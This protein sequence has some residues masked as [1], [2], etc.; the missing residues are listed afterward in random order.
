MSRR[1]VVISGVDFEPRG[2][3]PEVHQ[4]ILVALQGLGEFDFEYRP[5]RRLYADPVPFAAVVSEEIPPS[6]QVPAFKPP[7]D[8]PRPTLYLH[9]GYAGSSW[10][11]QA[12]RGDEYLSGAWTR[13]LERTLGSGSPLERLDLVAAFL[14]RATVDEGP[15]VVGAIEP[16]T[17]RVRSEVGLRP[18]LNGHVFISY[19]RSDA[20]RV[21]RM[22]KVLRGRGYRVW[23]DREDLAVGS[24]WR[25]EIAAA[26]RSGT[27]MV[28]CFS[29]AF[30]ARERSYMNE[31]LT[32]AIEEIRARPSDR[33]W[34]FPVRLDDCKIPDRSIGAGESLRDI[35]TLDLFPE[36]VDVYEPLIRALAGRRSGGLGRAT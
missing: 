9:H 10:G 11:G 3:S 2:S 22:V 17:E 30:A 16:P 29:S 12:W 35:H 32:L 21:D 25:Q 34:F 6:R 24:R 19:V 14:W 23:V 1:L 26:I 7:D 27:A 4:R 13:V 18:H 8:P 5:P 31:E 36:T 28:A 15:P 33:A 20:P